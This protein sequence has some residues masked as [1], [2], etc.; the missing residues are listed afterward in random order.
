M[1]MTQTSFREYLFLLLRDYSEAFAYVGLSLFYPLPAFLAL[2]G[3]SL[4]EYSW[5]RLSL[6]AA[7]FPKKQPFL[8][9]RNFRA[10]LLAVGILLYFFVQKIFFLN[11]VEFFLLLAAAAGFAFFLLNFFYARKIIIENKG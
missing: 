6:A 10:A 5:A 9:A 7:N 8:Q 1:T 11:P 2:A 3:F 4:S